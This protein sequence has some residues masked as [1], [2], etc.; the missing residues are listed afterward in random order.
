MGSLV[1]IMFGTVFVMVNSAGLRAPAP[2][3]IRLTGLLVV[4]AL[5][6]GLVLLARTV[7]VSPVSPVSSGPTSPEPVSPPFGRRYWCVVGVEAVALFGGVAVVTRVLHRPELSVA[8]VAVVV[9]LHFF[10]LAAL[11]AM[12]HFSR[13]GAVVTVLGLSGFVVH[14]LGGGP[15]LV[16]LVAGVGS[17]AALYGAVGVALWGALR[18]RPAVAGPTQDGAPGAGSA[19]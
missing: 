11:W 3:V 13:L 5:V 17:G 8:W 7:P 18:H 15:A 1:A 12:R 10:G 14:A 2:L 16:R 9:G 6:G 4:A 19:R